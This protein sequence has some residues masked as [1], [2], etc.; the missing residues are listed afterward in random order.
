MRAGEE[1]EERNREWAKNRVWGRGLGEGFGVGQ[2]NDENN[3][4]KMETVLGE[5]EKNELG[6][7]EKKNT[8]ARRG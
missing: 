3:K 7:G 2:R 5:R 8:V 6:L 4:Q 1:S